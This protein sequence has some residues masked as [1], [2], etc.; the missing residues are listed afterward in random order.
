MLIHTDQLNPEQ[1]TQLKQL[2]SN[3]KQTDGNSIPIY[4]HLISQKRSTPCNLLYYRDA[5]LIGF[6]SAFFFY[7]EACEIALMVDP[8]FRK[9]GISAQLIKEIL[10]LMQAKNIQ[11][12]IFSTAYGLNNHWLSAHDF[13]YQSSEYQMSRTEN[14]RVFADSK[15]II[16]EVAT[17]EDIKALS[18]IDKACFSSHVKD[19][20]ARF[21][22]LLNNPDYTLFIARKDG[23]PI[24][25]AH[26]YWQKSHAK[27]ADIAI[28]PRL[29]SRGFGCALLAY[30]INFSL[31]A[32]QPNITLEVET[33]N[34]NALRLYT[35]LGFVMKNAYDFWTIPV[36]ILSTKA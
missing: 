23:V 17:P 18:A 35:R 29:Q 7:E 24:G 16:V 15:S 9:Q 19:M 26:V 22:M 14:E 4:K 30:C 6:L 27:L 5:Q 28:I 10:P 12:L 34:Q 11:N 32:K 25:K 36:N 8:R 2:C 33:N 3:C 13:V 1:L 21:H 20:S 31:N